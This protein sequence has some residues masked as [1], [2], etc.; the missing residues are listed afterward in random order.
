[1]II[2][3]RTFKYRGGNNWIS[4]G[5]LGVYVGLT[6]TVAPPIT[7]EAIVICVHSEDRTFAV[8]AEDRTI[9]VESED[10]TFVVTTERVPC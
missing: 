8:L 6:V 5:V 4:A 1:M 3:P 7:P 9:S 10:R 2:E